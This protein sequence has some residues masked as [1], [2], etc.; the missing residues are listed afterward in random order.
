MYIHVVPEGSQVAAS[1][2]AFSCIIM[3]EHQLESVLV[4]SH[5]DKCRRCDK[6]G[7]GSASPYTMWT[8]G[9]SGSVVA[10]ISVWSWILT[11]TKFYA[12]YICCRKNWP[13]NIRL[14]SLSQ[15]IIWHFVVN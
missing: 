6:D 10:T 5:G 3:A 12:C 14:Y 13:F 4:G 7:G 9:S 8:V 2:C 1:H 11:F 15:H